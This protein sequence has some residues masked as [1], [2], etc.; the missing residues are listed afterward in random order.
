VTEVPWAVVGPLVAVVVVV[1]VWLLV[2]LWRHEVAQMPKWAWAA[3]ILLVT[4]PIGAL[5]YWFVGRVR[6]QELPPDADAWAPPATPAAP[7]DTAEATGYVVGPTAAGAA[8][9]PNGEVVLRTDRLRKVYDVAAIYE[10]ELRVPRGA[11]Y[12]LIGPNGAGKTTLLDLVAGL[13]IP[14]AGE[15]DVRVPRQ[16]IAV[17][18]DTPQFDPWLTAR[19]V[20]ELVA[21]LADT[22]LPAG[23]ADQ[24]LEGVDLAVAADRRVGGFSRG[25]LQRLGLASCLVGDP[26]LLLL[27]EPSS[28]LDPGGRREVLDLV[29]QLAG[30]RTVV[31]ST[32]V[33]SDVQQVCDTVGVL[34]GGRLVFQGPIEDLLAR[35]SSVYRLRTAGGADLE[36]R[37]D[38][39]DWVESVAREAAGGYR[40]VVTDVAAAEAGIAEV[41][42]DAGAALHAFGPASDLESAFLE[43]TEGRS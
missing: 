6:P 3:V 41:L 32:H 36:Q 28:A 43:L 12:G 37:L 2:D 23:G 39:V 1:D 40:L 19:E 26:Q 25:M 13:R 4:F 42:V 38:R 15:V 33:L 14:T 17:L 34:Q 35:T 9:E 11:V 27:D 30:D 24:A 18:P 10:V 29:G 16:R 5:V 20:V 8:W 22:Q 21:H 7:G 31:L